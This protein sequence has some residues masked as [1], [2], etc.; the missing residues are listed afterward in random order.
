MNFI[1]YVPLKVLLGSSSKL[2]LKLLLKGFLA[3]LFLGIGV[4]TLLQLIPA[5]SKY[6]YYEPNKALSLPYANSP[7]GPASGPVL[8]AP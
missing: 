3:M 5:V 1:H 4:E 8:P 6:F 2:N 7:P